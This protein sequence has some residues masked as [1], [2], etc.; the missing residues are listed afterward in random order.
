MAK[1]YGGLP[2]SNA[3]VNKVRVVL[4]QHV[5]NDKFGLVKSNKRRIPT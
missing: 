2:R 4:S 5:M 3:R 1:Q